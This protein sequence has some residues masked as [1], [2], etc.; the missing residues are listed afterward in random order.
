M[1]TSSKSN[2]QYK[3]PHAE[4]EASNKKGKGKRSEGPFHEHPSEDPQVQKRNEGQLSV[5]SDPEKANKK[6]LEDKAGAYLLDETSVDERERKDE[7]DE[8]VT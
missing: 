8:R 1:K 7:E 3:N 4:E 5:D 2:P 6:L